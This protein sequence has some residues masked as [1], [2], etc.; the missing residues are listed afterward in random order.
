MRGRGALGRLP[1]GGGLSGKERQWQ[2]PP[3]INY[4]DDSLSVFSWCRELVMENSGRAKI[5]QTGS[6]KNDPKRDPKF[7]T[8]RIAKFRAA[9]PKP[10][11]RRHKTERTNPRPHSAP[12]NPAPPDRAPKDTMAIAPVP[13]APPTPGGETRSSPRPPAQTARPTA[14]RQWRTAPQSNSANPPAPLC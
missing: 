1:R 6:L 10:P 14:G 4:S 8:R 5:F 9:T 12:P 3:D 11:A 2:R 13:E 7:R